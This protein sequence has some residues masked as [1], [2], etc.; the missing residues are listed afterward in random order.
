MSLWITAPVSVSVTTRVVD[1]LNPS[2]AYS[3]TLVWPGLSVLTYSIGL[4]VALTMS[5]LTPF[6]Q[7]T[8]RPVGM[9]HNWIVIELW[10]P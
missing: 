10:E 5:F 4:F 7:L 9:L 2:V 8:V 6:G 1:V 3:A